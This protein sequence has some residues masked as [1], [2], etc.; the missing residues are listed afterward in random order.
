MVAQPRR[1]GRLVARRGKRRVPVRGAVRADQMVGDQAHDFV[2]LLGGD[3]HHLHHGRAAEA[4]GAQPAGLERQLFLAG[5]GLGI[6]VGEGKGAG[7]GPFPGLRGQGE[8]LHVGGIEAD[9]A[10]KFHDP[11][12]YA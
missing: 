4:A 1:V 10:G 9:G 11:G 3:V 6:D 5:Q 8:H 2:V 7:H 12:L